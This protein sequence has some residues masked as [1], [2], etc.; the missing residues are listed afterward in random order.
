MDT[1]RAPAGLSAR[2]RAF[3]RRICECYELEDHALRILEQA[4][5]TLDRIQEDQE[6]VSRDGRTYTD[7]YGQPRLHPC[8]D[9]ERQ[10]RNLLIRLLRELRLDD[11]PDEARPPR[12]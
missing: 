8:L 7:R 10:Q 4:C 11:L 6:T 1:P 12:I 3:W 9:D 5:R 2:S